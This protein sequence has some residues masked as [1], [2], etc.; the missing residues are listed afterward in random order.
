MRDYDPNIRTP[1]VQSWSFGI[2]RELDRNTALEVRY[3]GNRSIGLIQQFQLN[4]VNI[5]E[6]GFLDEFKLAQRNLAISRAAGR[7]NNFANR[8]IAGQVPLPIFEASFGGP[9]NAN[10]ANANFLLDLDRGLAAT[11]AGR[12]ATTLAFHNNR[13]TRGLAP[14]LFLVNPSNLTT[15]G[16]QTN[17]EG[18]WYNGM[19]VEVRRRLAN[20]LLVQG[21]YTW[22]RSLET[23][24]ESIRNIQQ[25]KATSEFDIRHA[26]KMDYIYELPFGSGRRFQG[27]GG[28]IGKL[29]EGWETDGIA[30]WQSGRQFTIGCG[31]ATTTG[32]D[33]CILVGMTADDLQK[34]I[35]IR[36][37]GNA[38]NIGNV[39]WLPE[40]I[41]ENT[42]RAFGTLTDAPPTGRYIAPPTTP[43]VSGAYYQLYGP[44]FFRA[45]I[46][47]VKKTRVTE[48]VN[49]EFRTEFLNAFN[50]INFL[51]GSPAADA[52]GIGVGGLTFGQTN[53]AYNDLSTTNDPGGRLIQ[54]VFRVN[55]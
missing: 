39:F 34:A 25:H 44:G 43:G 52:T 35:R 16:L 8:G 13:V 4:E 32:N 15:V 2:Q 21:S 9:T 29:I 6:N 7:G 36:K 48:T 47:I 22:S 12:L 41:I 30:R 3:V 20:G 42:Q 40:D 38:A 18:S 19:V 24:G 53:Q 51:I 37:P 1:Y 50:N 49:V 33:G 28:V 17:G 45:D 10:F 23:F 46:S 11:S 31:R 5:F 55:F 54:F 26:F 27:P 14:N